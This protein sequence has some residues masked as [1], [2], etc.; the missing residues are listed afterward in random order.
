MLT[1]DLN[2]LA[3]A[4]AG[5]RAAA[6]Y[7]DLLGLIGRQDGSTDS[8]SG[9]LTGENG[10]VS[11]ES[12][13]VSGVSQVQ[14]AGTDALSE[15]QI[16]SLADGDVLAQ[17]ADIAEAEGFPQTAADSIR[18]GTMS[19]RDFLSLLGKVSGME[20]MPAENAAESTT[21]PEIPADIKGT[22]AAPADSTDKTAADVTD[23]V[24]TA[25]V[26]QAGKDSV[27]KFQS[28]SGQAAA[29]MDEKAVMDLIRNAG[30]MLENGSSTQQPETDGGRLQ[31]LLRLLQSEP[32]K[33]M[34]QDTLTRQWQLTPSDVTDKGS[35]KQ[36]YE[37]ILRQTEEIQNVLSRHDMLQSPSGGA[38]QNLRS[39]V[40]FINQ[41]NQTFSYV[42][43]PV[44]LADGSAHGDLYVYTNK[45][46]LSK[47]DGTVTALLHLDMAA[48]G[49]MDVY[50]AMN[51]QNHVNTHFYLQDEESLDLIASHIDELD[52][53]LADKGYS[54]TSELS[55][56]DGMTQAAEEIVSQG[57]SASKLI[58]YS[59]F[60]AR[61]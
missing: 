32:V 61:A 58:S 53:H 27:T 16:G 6:V 47:G 52:R 57:R 21:M 11:S 4:G 2:G 42:Q 1:D 39:N 54:M 20:S 23:N 28:G 19:V 35:V 59:S 10:N 14:P 55:V 49:P 46:N 38:I 44:K 41:I 60:D 51:R 9:M 45:K 18:N 34:I 15:V 13:M 40:D 36:L 12:R 43:L 56:R 31:P 37:R 25:D 17:A 50:I 7:S 8:A 30:K 22:G 24:K 29:R 5:E 26:A 33:K 48:L 3:A